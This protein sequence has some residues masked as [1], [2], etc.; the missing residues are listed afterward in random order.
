MKTTHA[1]CNLRRVRML[2]AYVSLHS[3]I[4]HSTPV[5]SE[6]GVEGAYDPWGQLRGALPPPK[7]RCHPLNF[8]RQKVWLYDPVNPTCSLSYQFRYPQSLRHHP[9]LSITYGYV[10]CSSKCYL[11]SFWGT[12]IRVVTY[13]V[14]RRSVS[15]LA[16][17]DMCG[18]LKRR[19]RRS[20]DWTD[21]S[22]AANDSDQ[23]QSSICKFNLV[24]G[25]AGGRVGAINVNVRVF[26]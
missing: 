1:L 23:S 9:T 19:C 14:F 22:G 16:A 15:A 24:G 3:L 6:Q 7:F 21:Q 26:V 5:A 13:I 4:I 18:L 12:A 17:Q 8:N 25:R 20:C 11:F 2:K 10:S